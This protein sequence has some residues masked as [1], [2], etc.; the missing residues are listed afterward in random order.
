MDVK[1]LLL[2]L[3]LSCGA[4]SLSQQK[5][6]CQDRKSQK[7]AKRLKSQK[8]G[9]NFRNYKN[10]GNRPSKVPL[11]ILLLGNVGKLAS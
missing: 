4:G 9:N 2:N 8:S 1:S 7:I 3:L 5:N 6:N 11:W 10:G